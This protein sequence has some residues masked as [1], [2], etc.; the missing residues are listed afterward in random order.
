MLFLTSEGYG[1]DCECPQSSHRKLP[2]IPW[3]RES[4]KPLGKVIK[5]LTT[6]DSIKFWFG[7]S[8]FFKSQK[9]CKIVV[10]GRVDKMGE[11]MGHF[12]SWAGGCWL[13]TINATSPLTRP[14]QAGRLEIFFR[15]RSLTAA[16][17]FLL[18]QRRVSG[19]DRQSGVAE[20]GGRVGGNGINKAEHPP[21]PSLKKSKRR[22]GG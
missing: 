13:S 7:G 10:E 1:E 17:K 2:E 19:R 20:R 21:S 6:R 15:E 5:S 14:N 4:R 18:F 12:P 11:Q 16:G 8:G 9:N 3:D 22:K